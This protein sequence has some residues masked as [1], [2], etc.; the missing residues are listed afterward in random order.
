MRDTRP[1]NTE[2]LKAGIKATW[3]SII[4][5]QCR[6]LT[7]SMPR[8]I[9]AVGYLMQKDSRP[10]VECR[11]EHNF[12]EDRHFC[13]ENT[14]W[15]GSVY[16]CTY[17]QYIHRAPMWDPCSIQPSQHHRAQQSSILIIQSKSTAFQKY[18]LLDVSLHHQVHADNQ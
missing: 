5:E 10:S 7:G 6:R 11:H 9:E 2:E 16:T 17:I 18:P 8:R 1:N 14:V 13:F 3:A 4:P 12:S 15:K